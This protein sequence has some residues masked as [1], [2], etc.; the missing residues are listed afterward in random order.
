[1]TFHCDCDCHK[2][3]HVCGGPFIMEIGGRV[4]P[5]INCADTVVRDMVHSIEGN[6]GW[7]GIG[8]GLGGAIIDETP[9][10]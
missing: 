8:T 10:V 7:S 5:H 3:C 4:Q 1:M 6:W 9:D 2:T